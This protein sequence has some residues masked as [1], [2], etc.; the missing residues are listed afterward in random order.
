MVGHY[1]TCLL[2]KPTRF[3]LSPEPSPRSVK[4]YNTRYMLQHPFTIYS[5]FEAVA[6]TFNPPAPQEGK[7]VI[8][9]HHT[10]SARS[11]QIVVAEEYRDLFEEEPGHMGRPF[12][13]IRSFVG[14]GC[15]PLFFDSIKADTDVMVGIV[16]GGCG[17]VP[18]D[19]L[20]DDQ[21]ERMVNAVSVCI[22][23]ERPLPPVGW[24]P[25]EA[26]PPEPQEFTAGDDRVL[27]HDHFTGK[28]RGVAHSTCNFQTSLSKNY[29]VPVFFH[30]LKGYDGYHVLRGT[31]HWKGVESMKC[32]A[33]S[34]EKFSAL[35]LNG[36][37]RFVDSLQFLSGSL[38]AL[39]RNLGSG[40]KTPEEE[41][42]VYR[43]LKSWNRFHADGPETMKRLTKKGIY[44]YDLVK[45]VSDLLDLRSLPP[46]EDFRNSLKDKD[47]SDGE[48]RCTGWA[49][50]YFQCRHLADYTAAYCELDVILLACV[51]EQFRKSMLESHKLDPT[52]FV[53]LPGYSWQ[54][55]LL[56]QRKKGVG[57]ETV[58]P[59][60]VGYDG[61][62]MI[63]KGIQGGICQVMQPC[64][65]GRYFEPEEV[66]EIAPGKDHGE[67]HVLHVDEKQP[68]W[69]RHVRAPAP[70]RLEVGEGQVG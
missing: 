41:A 37:V 63:R 40:I 58:T 24:K 7:T 26:F 52:H 17:N 6:E 59:D 20:T 2:N 5:D 66:E 47:I 18:I 49:W 46:R 65:E 43:L 55:M 33:K 70:E 36:T 62:L 13:E 44:P 57:L 56:H 64:V 29:A 22:F 32:I 23:C 50:D 21:Y 19:F 30:N 25:R 67:Q 69:G 42:R 35:T 54:A 38:D 12:K 16:K 8:L 48:Y 45:K 1:N 53:T 11:Y 28:I 9:S 31:E 68:L 14:E 39:V 34:L 27:D 60:N 10:V 15:M 61:M 4:F 3:S 51:F